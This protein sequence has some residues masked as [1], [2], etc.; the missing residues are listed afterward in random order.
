MR[1][2]CIL[3]QAVDEGVMIGSAEPLMLPT[4]GHLAWSLQIGP[5]T[6]FERLQAEAQAAI[7]YYWRLKAAPA[8]CRKISR[9]ERTVV[10]LAFTIILTAAA[11]GDEY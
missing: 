11:A 1:A 2:G 8:L 4:S 7:P 6:H 3:S 9:P 10:V 5:A